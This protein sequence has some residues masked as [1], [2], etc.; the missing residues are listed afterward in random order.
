MYSEKACSAYNT[1]HTGP[2]TQL[3]GLNAGFC[4]SAYHPGIALAVKTD[5]NAAAEKQA[6][7][8]SIKMIGRNDD[9]VSLPMLL[10]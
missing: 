7:S 6:T 8:D 2:N 5:P 1:V 4:N 3:G 10:L 9:V